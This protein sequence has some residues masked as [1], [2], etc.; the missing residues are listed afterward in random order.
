MPR[1]ARALR[2]GAPRL[3]RAA[4]HTTRTQRAS[5]AARMHSTAAHGPAGRVLSGQDNQWFAR[6]SSARSSGSSFSHQ[7]TGICCISFLAAVRAGLPILSP[8][9]ITR[10]NATQLQCE[11]CVVLPAAQ[12]SH[13]A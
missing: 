4:E 2:A 5:G 10:A 7:G 9:A 6:I 3:H 13:Y 11:G 12:G 8:E 1:C